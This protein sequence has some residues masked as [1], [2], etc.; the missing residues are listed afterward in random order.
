MLQAS[1]NLHLTFKVRCKL[2]KSDI[3]QFESVDISPTQ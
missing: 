2:R 3:T 1:L